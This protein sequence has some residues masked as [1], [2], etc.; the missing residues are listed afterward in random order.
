MLFERELAAWCDDP[1]GWPAKRDLVTFLQWFEP[2][3]RSVVIDLVD[4][5]LEDDEA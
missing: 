1:Q 5:P 3:L 4:A 2:Q